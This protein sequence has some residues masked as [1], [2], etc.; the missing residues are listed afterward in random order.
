MR[1]LHEQHGES[2]SRLYKIWRGMLE[3]CYYKT[4]D[5]FPHYGGR[6]INVCDEWRKSYVAFSSWAKASGYASHKSIDR[7]DVDGNYCQENC[8]WSTDKQQA[9][10]R[11]Y[12]KADILVTHDG[13][14]LNI[15][16]WSR[17][18]RINYTTLTKRYNNGKLGADLFAVPRLYRDAFVVAAIETR[19][20]KAK[21]T[22]SQV[23]EVRN[24]PL[25]GADSA[26]QFHVAQSTVSMIRSGKRRDIANSV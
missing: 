25:R 22:K 8:R 20:G 26:K 3:R 14:V 1:K 18:L 23:D 15:S 9:R 13:K 21:L 10:N 2:S 24:S 7:I 6:G 16:E 4:H 19:N 5:S 17:L 12:G 11:R